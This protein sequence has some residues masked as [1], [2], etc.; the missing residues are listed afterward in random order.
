MLALKSFFYIYIKVEILS[1]LPIKKALEMPS[2]PFLAE[3]TQTPPSTADYLSFLVSV[4]RDAT[5]QGGRNLIVPG[6]LKKI[7]VEKLKLG[8]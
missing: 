3:F 5:F 7:Q 8:E 2:G 4:C 1:F 6:D